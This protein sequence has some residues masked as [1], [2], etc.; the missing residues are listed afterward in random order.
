MGDAAMVVGHAKNHQVTI[1]GTMA[2]DEDKDVLKASGLTMIAF[3]KQRQ[4]EVPQNPELWSA[5]HSLEGSPF[6]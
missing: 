1:T 4:E 2:K 3:C 6:G 5:R